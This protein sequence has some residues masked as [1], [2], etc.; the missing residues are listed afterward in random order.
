V[1]DEERIQTGF[2]LNSLE[3][4]LVIF[5]QVDST[6]LQAKE[7]LHSKAQHGTIVIAEQQTRGVGRLRRSWYSPKGGLYFSVI[8]RELAQIESLP[9]YGLLAACVIHESLK[10]LTDLQ[11]SL[12]WPNDVLLG[13]KK[14]SGVLSEYVVN[15]IHPLGI[16]V[17]VGINLNNR[18]E[19]FPTELQASATTILS[20]TKQESSVEDLLVA[21]ISRL[22][23]WLQSDPELEKVVQVYK[24]ICGTLGRFVSA[25]F[26]GRTMRG[27]A[28]DV[29]ADGFLIV[30]DASGKTVHIDFG[31]IVHLGSV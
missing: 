2:S 17:G 15:G 22:D 5:D 11:F 25:D 14:V 20:A 10:Q 24:R 7:L 28:V 26:Q 21:I 29:D 3:H 18:I 6:N 12:K 13:Q 1:I 4:H 30:E 8:L 19:E 31:D 16:I 9:L 27:K 23:W